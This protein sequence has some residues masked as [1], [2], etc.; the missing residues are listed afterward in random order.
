MLAL[1]RLLLIALLVSACS[2]TATRQEVALQ[3]APAVLQALA[4]GV[5]L[6]IWF[7]YRGRPGIDPARW[8]PDAEDWRLIKALGF[9]H[10]RVQFDPAYFRDPIRPGSLQPSR[11]AD[12]KTA[13]APAWTHGLVVVLAAE[14]EGP[15]KLRLLKDEAGVGELLAFWRAFAGA[16]SAVP[17]E[18]LVFELLNE[19]T[20]TDAV[21]N[22]LLMRRLVEAAR[23]AAPRRTLVV[24]GHRYS[25]PDELLA[26][27]P[28]AL[29]NLIYSFHFYEPHTF[30]HQGAFWGWPMFMKFS[31]LPYP[32]SP[33]ALAPLVEPVDVD[34]RPHLISYGDQRWDRARIDARLQA[35]R[36]WAAATGVAVWCGEFGVSRLGPP[37]DSRR[38][39]LADVRASLE[40]RQIGWTLFDYTGHFGLTTGLAGARQLDPLDAAAL[41]LPMPIRPMAQ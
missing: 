32:S 40:D 27:E 24:E 41:N 34:A 13:L 5:N 39:W 26:F 10:V 9:R 21:S 23:S 4:R 28:L 17:P 37:L 8:Y 31:Q 36:D 11:L 18:Q 29:P 30:T 19:P 3:P 14:P 33:Q 35:V 16:L 25:G 22:R 1:L 15:E 12:L 7:T 6:P 38:R 2:S 20:E